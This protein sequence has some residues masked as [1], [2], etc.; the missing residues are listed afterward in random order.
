[1][2]SISKPI[3]ILLIFYFLIV[4]LGCDLLTDPEDDCDN[5][6][7][8]DS[9][10]VYKPNIYIYPE[11]EST[12]SVLLNFPSGGH[13]TI[14]DPEYGDGWEVNVEPTGV[15]NGEHSFLFYESV[16]PN[17]CQFEEGWLVYQEDLSTFFIS[18]LESLLFND[19]EIRDF[20]DYW[21]PLL[22][23]QDAY[24]IYPQYSKTLDQMVIINCNPEPRS[25]NRVWYVIKGVP[26]GDINLLT[27]SPVTFDRQGFHIMEWGVIL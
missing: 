3:N 6:D 8:S 21:I 13:V 17:F 11:V 22:Q 16:I 12:L 23:E 9:V 15:I 10:V 26:E 20:I 18:E 25:V 2:K 27:P 19:Q 4:G 5:D 14:S 1:M 24:A 7:S